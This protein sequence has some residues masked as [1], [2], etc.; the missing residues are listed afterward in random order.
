MESK[1]LSL[2]QRDSWW[3]AVIVF[4]TVLTCIIN[5]PECYA[6][7]KGLEARRGRFLQLGLAEEIGFSFSSV[8]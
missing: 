1:G 7:E 6:D 4:A 3:P 5:Y 2:W 8:C